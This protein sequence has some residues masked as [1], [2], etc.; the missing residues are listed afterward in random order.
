MA[1]QTNPSSPAAAGTPHTIPSTAILTTEKFYLRRYEA[2][3]AEAMAAAANDPELAKY[4]RSRFPSPYTPA[5]AQSFI[6]HCASLPPEH[7]LTF[8]IFTVEGGELAG[9]VSLEPPKGDPI[10]GGTREL[11]YWVSRSFWGRGGK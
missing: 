11:G 5:D 9:T 8:G 7:A 3:D 1:I 2:S 10:Y 6:A 4:L